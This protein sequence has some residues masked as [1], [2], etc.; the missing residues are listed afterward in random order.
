M[1]NILKLFS[2]ITDN[3]R[4]ADSVALDLHDRRHVGALGVLDLDGDGERH[5]AEVLL[6]L[7]VGVDGSVALLLRGRLGDGCRIYQYMNSL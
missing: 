2:V 7:V 4:F 6:E 5:L 1:S 3:H